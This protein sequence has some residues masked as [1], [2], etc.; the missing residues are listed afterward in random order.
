MVTSRTDQVPSS[1]ICQKQVMKKQTNDLKSLFKMR[2]AV[3]QRN[4]NK[5][6]QR[7]SQLRLTE[8]MTFKLRSE[9]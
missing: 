6:C 1:E 2:V 4:K 8:R 9:G 5:K 7:D 3:K